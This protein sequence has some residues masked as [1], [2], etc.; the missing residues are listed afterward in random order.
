MTQITVPEA[1]KTKSPTYRYFCELAS[2]ELDHEGVPES[3]RLVDVVVL[4][5]TENAIKT[6]V[7][8]TDW[9][10]GYTIVAHWFPDDGAEF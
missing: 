2:E 4:E 6:V 7:A 1:E 3:H 9:L 5:N 8:A 10:S